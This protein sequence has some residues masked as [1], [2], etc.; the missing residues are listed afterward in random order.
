MH[1]SLHG[2]RDNAYFIFD[3]RK[4]QHALIRVN[5]EGATAGIIRFANGSQEGGPGGVIFDGIL[6]AS[7]EDSIR[8]FEHQMA[9]EWKGTI[10]LQ[11][12]IR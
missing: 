4:G 9:N 10:L 12:T 11:V 8:V 1:D 5:G 7:G 6:P 2:M 3:A